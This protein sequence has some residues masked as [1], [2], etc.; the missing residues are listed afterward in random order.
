MNYIITKIIIRIGL[1]VQEFWLLNLAISD[2]TI[3]SHIK[4]IHFFV[5]SYTYFSMC[6]FFLKMFKYFF[7][8]HSVSFLGEA[9]RQITLLRPHPRTK[10]HEGQYTPLKYITCLSNPSS[11]VVTSVMAQRGLTLKHYLKQHQSSP[12]STHIILSTILCLY[13]FRFCKRQYFQKCAISA[14]YCYTFYF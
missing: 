10:E 6:I 11:T 9:P 14:D 8:G 13:Y 5:K 1:P 7:Q 2:H 12:H 4:R 3:K